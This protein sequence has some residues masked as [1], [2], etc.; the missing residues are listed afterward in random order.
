VAQIQ[1]DQLLDYADRKRWDRLEAEK[2]LGP[3][4]Q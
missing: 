2:W 4:F 3:N 1:E